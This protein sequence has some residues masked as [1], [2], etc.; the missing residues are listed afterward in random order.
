MTNNEKINQIRGI[1]IDAAV[2]GQKL[3]PIREYNSAEW[4]YKKG[5]ADAMVRIKTIVCDIIDEDED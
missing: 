1:V 5:W 4:I 2:N 3:S